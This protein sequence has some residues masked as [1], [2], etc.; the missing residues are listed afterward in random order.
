MTELTTCLSNQQFRLYGKNYDNQIVNGTMTVC[1]GV[2]Q[3]LEKLCNISN[4]DNVDTTCVIPQAP[5]IGYIDSYVFY[6]KTQYSERYILFIIMLCYF[7]L[8]VVPVCY[9]TIRYIGSFFSN[10]R[11]DTNAMKQMST[12][13]TSYNTFYS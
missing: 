5:S 12:L 6:T 1:T 3:C 4:N 2:F 11:G 9:F 7:T 8:T 10:N 13:P